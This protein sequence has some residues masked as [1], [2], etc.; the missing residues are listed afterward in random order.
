MKKGLILISFIAAANI[1][2]AQQSESTKVKY[3]ETIYFEIKA[4]DMPQGMPPGM[5]DKMPKNRSS[6][7]ILYAT[8]TK[9]LYVVN[10]E[11][12]VAETED[13]GRARWGMRRGNVDGKVFC[14]YDD[15]SMVTYTDMFGKEFIIKEE[16]EYTW[17]I[18]SGEQRDI[19]GQTCIKATY[20]KDSTTVT[21][22]YAPKIQIPSG[23]DGYSGLP[24]IILAVSEGDKKVI[25]A[26]A[27]EEHFTAA[28]A[29]EE[30]TKGEVVTRQKYDEIRKQKMKEMREMYGGGAGGSVRMNGRG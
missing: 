27:L 4:G 20:L 7:K 11:D 23:P 15:L 10:K 29:I 9:S 5:A 1:I 13:S 28:P 17:K 18:H 2:F 6:N 19:L 30:P 3:N 22:W 14:N 8:P 12:K 26:T 21:A 25:L 24:G 16:K